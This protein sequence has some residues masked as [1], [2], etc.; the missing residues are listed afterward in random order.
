MATLKTTSDYANTF[1][2]HELSFFARARCAVCIGSISE[3]VIRLI[4]PQSRFSKSNAVWGRQTRR[5]YSTHMDAGDGEWGE[6]RSE[7]TGTQRSVF[8]GHLRV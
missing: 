4:R 6:E 5:G 8:N 7:R 2:G 1:N 3:S